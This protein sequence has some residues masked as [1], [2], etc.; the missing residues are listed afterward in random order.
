MTALINPYWYAGPATDPYFANVVLLLHCDGTNGSTAN[1]VDNSPAAHTV[2]QT[3]TSLTTGQFKFGTASLDNPAGGGT[4]AST[5]DSNDW[6]FAGGQFTVECWIRPTAAISGL[7]YP[8]AQWGGAGSRAWGLRLNGGAPGFLDFQYSNN[9]TGSLFVS[10]AYL[11]PTNTWTHLAADRD[12]GNTLRI[13]ADGVV[14][15]SGSA[16][17]G[18]AN[19]TT[20]LRIGSDLTGT[21]SFVGQ[22]DDIRITKGVARYAGAFTPPTAPFPDS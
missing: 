2:T 11:P 1:L 18:I 14:I 15:G 17:V 20:P 12:A 16:G 8:L 3:G 4:Y 9:L 6:N 5:P 13:Y 21:N 10:G 22:I 7:Q 19:S